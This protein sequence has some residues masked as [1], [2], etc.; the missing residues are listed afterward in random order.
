MINTH[1]HAGLALDDKEMDE[2]SEHGKQDKEQPQENDFFQRI[3]MQFSK[4]A[5]KMDA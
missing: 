2:I 4:P 3:K 5:G 1:A